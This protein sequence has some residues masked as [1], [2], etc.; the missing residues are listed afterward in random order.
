MVDL[1]PQG[2]HGR[3]SP[4]L[5]EEAQAHAQGHDHHDDGCVGP[6]ARECREEGRTHEEDEDRVADLPEQDGAGAH[7]ASAQGVRSELAEPVGRLDGREPVRVAGQLRE[8]FG[9]PHGGGVGQVQAARRDHT[10]RRVHAHLAGPPAPGPLLPCGSQ[11]PPP[12]R[13]LMASCSRNGVASRHE[14]LTLPRDRRS[15]TTDVKDHEGD[16][17]W[18]GQC[19]HVHRESGRLWRC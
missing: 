16:H 11:S 18:P 1:A 19:C 13:E 15:R 7:P 17:T 5:V 6:P 2:G 14:P 12:G 4:V 9:G 8:H 10:R 3:L